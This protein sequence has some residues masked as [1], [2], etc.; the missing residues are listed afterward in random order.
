MLCVRK[1]ALVLSVQAVIEG[2]M[3]KLSSQQG[4]L[5]LYMH[6]PWCESC[7]SL[8]IRTK[9]SKSCSWDAR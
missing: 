7:F 3:C 5:S 2:K 6:S 4:E 1:A 8:C 9:Y